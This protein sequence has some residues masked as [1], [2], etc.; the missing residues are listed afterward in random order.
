ML[1]DKSYKRKRIDVLFHQ[2]KFEEIGNLEGFKIIEFRNIKQD[3][4]NKY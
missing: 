3:L 2:D 1:I 4:K